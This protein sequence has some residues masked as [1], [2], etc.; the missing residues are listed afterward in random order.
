MCHAYPKDEEFGRIYQNTLKW[1][2]T[3]QFNPS[4]NPNPE[5]AMGMEKCQTL[6]PIHD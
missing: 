5:Q 1:Q 6:T 4:I 2:V 3:M